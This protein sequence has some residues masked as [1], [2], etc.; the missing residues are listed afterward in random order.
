VPP[1]HR[2]TMQAYDEAMRRFEATLQALGEAVCALWI[3]L[4]QAGPSD[5]QLMRGTE[6]LVFVTK[7]LQTLINIMERHR[8]PRR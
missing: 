2:E 3:Q 8:D 4:L 5:P 7:H 6:I 1:T